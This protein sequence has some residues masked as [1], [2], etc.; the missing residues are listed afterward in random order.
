MSSAKQGNYLKTKM[1]IS[2]RSDDFVVVASVDVLNASK[3]VNLFENRTV[4]FK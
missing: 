4:K 3:N 2:G 1:A